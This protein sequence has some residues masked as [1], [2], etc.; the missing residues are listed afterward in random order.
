VAVWLH[1]S[2]IGILRDWPS[3]GQ[4]ID[5]KNENHSFDDLAI[6]QSRNATLT[7]F[8]KPQR[9]DILQTSSNLLRMLGAKPQ[10]GRLLLPG[11]DKPESR[12]WLF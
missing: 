7:G 9:V 3:P 2:G 4:Y 5:L 6:A 10:L 12:R 1:S 8:D 11:E